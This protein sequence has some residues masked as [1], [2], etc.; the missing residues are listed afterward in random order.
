MGLRILAFQHHPA[1]PASFVGERMAMRTA[2]WRCAR[3]G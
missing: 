2:E 3:P 1:S